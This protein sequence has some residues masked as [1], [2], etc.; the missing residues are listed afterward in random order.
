[1]EKI[2]P[3][4]LVKREMKKNHY[5]A[6]DLGRR[7]NL[8]A[9][10]I[11][12]MLNSPTMQVQRLV[13]LSDFLQ[14]NFFREIAE[15]LPYANPVILNAEKETQ[16]KSLEEQNQALTERNKELEMEVKVLRETIRNIT[17]R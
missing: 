2:I 10:T 14:Y 9:S 1:M 7:L 5:T 17:L 8:S 12:T 4:S 15:M 6:A 16:I 3:V 11:M 13:D